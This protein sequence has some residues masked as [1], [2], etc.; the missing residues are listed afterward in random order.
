MTT[1]IGD[2]SFAAL[3]ESLRFQVE[4]LKKRCVKAEQE[5]AALNQQLQEQQTRMEELE[6]SNQELTEKYNGLQAGTVT[7][8]SAEEISKLRD[9]YLAMIREIDLCLSRLNG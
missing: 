5:A 4:W 2:T 6:K 3:F 7:G 8:A 1:K 9:R